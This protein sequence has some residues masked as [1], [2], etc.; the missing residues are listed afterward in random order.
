M[1]RYSRAA[2]PWTLVGVCAVILLALMALV[3]YQ[4]LVLW[5]L[6]GT[7]VGVVAA[8]TAWCLDEPAAG[9]VDPTPHTMA[10]RTTARL[11]GILTVLAAW[12]AG[13]WWA[14]DSLLDHPWTVF[15][16][17][18]AASAL[19]ACWVIR[20]R[21][22]GQSTPG[23]RFAL[24][25]I[26]LA[27]AWALVRPFDSRLPVFPYVWS[28]WSAALWMWSL[29]GL[30]S[31]AAAVL[32]LARDGRLSRPPERAGRARAGKGSVGGARLGG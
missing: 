9:V 6:Q 27:T 12:S 30:A 18:P 11:P 24:A 21:F 14:R 23:G 26:P 2:L 19:A 16:Q 22:A 25:V 10:W 5:P 32:L 31:A 20:A 1:W 29:A 7:A 3:E 13:A 17:G 28:N 4:P 15:V 8:A